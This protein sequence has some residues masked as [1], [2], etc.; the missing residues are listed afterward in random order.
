M[1]LSFKI[2]MA[3]MMVYFCVCKMKFYLMIV[4]LIIFIEG[5]TFSCFDRHI[6]NRFAAN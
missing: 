5:T 1:S 6:E 4:C 2:E 3:L